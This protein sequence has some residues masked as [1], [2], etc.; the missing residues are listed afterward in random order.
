MLVFFDRLRLDQPMFDVL[1][2]VVVL[3]LP[4]AVGGAAGRLAA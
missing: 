2:Q 4:A 3:G 1:G